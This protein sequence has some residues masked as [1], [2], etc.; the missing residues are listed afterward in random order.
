MFSTKPRYFPRNLGVSSPPGAN[1][2]E[3]LV[4]WNHELGSLAKILQVFSTHKVKVVQ[5]H[6]Q[7][8]EATGTV[9]GT[10]YCDMTKADQTVEEVQKAIKELSFVRSADAASA[11]SSLF[12][13][14]LF[15][16]T[17]WGRERVIIMR[18]SPLLNIEKSL[19]EELGSAGSAIMFREGEGY[20][21]ETI[22]QYRAVLGDVSAQVLLKNVVDGLRATGWGL[23]EFK[24]SKDGYEVTVRD[25][26]MLA[27][28][29]EPSRF[30]CG[31]I[32]GVLES[33]LSVRMKIVESTV[34]PKSGRLFVR[35]SKTPDTKS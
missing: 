23:F 29:T 1:V 25:A 35:L 10:Y 34:E 3:F 16:V 21:T 27:T 13:K 11:E 4:V 5:T 18:L 30:L 8:D 7:L 17:V 6:S 9:V 12:D 24:E 14:F 20:A 15:P 33:V 28:T 31:I 32:A 26:P 22:A 19:V 2:H